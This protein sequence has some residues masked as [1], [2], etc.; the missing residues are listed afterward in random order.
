[1]KKVA[2]NQK[3]IRSTNLNLIIDLVR[4]QGPISRADVAKILKLSAPSVSSNIEQLLAMEIL[5]EVGTRDIVS[6]GRPP[7]LLRFNRH[8]GYIIAIDLAGDR[9]R[10]AVGDLMGEIIAQ[11]EVSFSLKSNI[12]ADD[13][14]SVMNKM[15][16][17]LGSK[18]ISQ[19]KLKV[20]CVGTPGIINKE[21]GYFKA[22]PRFKEWD[23]I[24]IHQLMKQEMDADVM[25]INDMNLNVIGENRYGAGKGF[26]NLLGINI[27]FGIGAGLIIDGRLYEGSRLA[28]G[29]VGYWVCGSP[30]FDEP[31]QLKNNYL[32]YY[33]SLYALMNTVK[34]DLS[35]GAESKITDYCKGNLEMVDFEA[36]CKATADG[37][38]YCMQKTKELVQSLAIV[39][40]N[41]SVLLD[42]E[43]II[44][45]GDIVKLGY[46]FIQPLRELVNGMV[47]LTTTIVFSEL[48]ERSGI[49]GGFAVALDRVM[50]EIL[51]Q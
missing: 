20:V 4:R 15:K 46:K 9:I 24:N 27:D 7:I 41:M 39:L 22:A 42:L 32:D 11:D 16:E 28:A 23:T 8:Y 19:E 48:G 21:T 47:P 17:L 36:F 35:N 37:D 43:L 14:Y 38:P 25:V 1:M 18:H 12:T 29:E 3:L 51:P 33:S 40:A 50:Q 6:S 49:Y 13:F 34:R 2:G 44:V 5:E 26:K 45:G 31:G 10:M 30:N